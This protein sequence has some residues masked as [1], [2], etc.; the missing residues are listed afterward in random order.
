MKHT[1]CICD[2]EQKTRQELKEYILQYSFSNNLDIDAFEMSSAND[3]LSCEQQYD[4][5]FLDIKFKREYVGIKVA[6][7]LRQRGN[8]AIIVI[9]TAFGAMAIEGYR[10]EAYRFI[11][12]PFSEEQICTLLDECMAKL[13][14]TIDYIKIVSASQAKQI[15]ADKV[16][17]VYSLTRKRH[18]VC[19][20]VE[21]L[22]WQS[23]QEIMDNLPSDRFAYAQKSYIVNLGFV[24]TIRSESIILI[25]GKEIPMGKLYREDFM[26]KLQAWIKR[27]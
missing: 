5:L 15:R 21:L 2:D 8:N 9:I 16:L 3:L 12:K 4:I 22:T 1:V 19:N 7:E 14:K 24:D 20:D 17:Y 27:K 26:K 6:E 10:A 25:N 13:Y 23:L 11:V 18:V